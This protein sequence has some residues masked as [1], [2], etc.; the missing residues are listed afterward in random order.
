MPI[1]QLITN[2]DSQSKKFNTAVNGYMPAVRPEM[3]GFADGLMHTSDNQCSIKIAR[4]DELL[5]H[6]LIVTSLTV[7]PLFL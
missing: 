1:L 6:R 7:P 5:L 4:I 3:D 2:H